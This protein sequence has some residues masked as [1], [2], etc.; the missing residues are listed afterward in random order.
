MNDT[1]LRE[2]LHDVASAGVGPDVD[3]RVARLASEAREGQGRSAGRG[4]RRGWT[5]GALGVAAVAVAVL[6]VV[7]LAAMTRSPVVVPASGPGSLPD[8]I[9]PTREHILTLEQ[10]PIGRV[11]MVYAGPLL[12]GATSWVA[13]GA[14]SDDYRALAPAS[15]HLGFNKSVDVAADG[16]T[17]AVGRGGRSL[18]VE[19]I[20]AG[21]GQSSFVSLPDDGAGG[22]VDSISWGSSDRRLAVTANIIDA[23]DPDRSSGRVSYYVVEADSGKVAALPRDAVLAGEIVGWTPDG[24]V[25]LMDGPGESGRLR[26]SAADEGGVTRVADIDSVPS[27]FGRP[28]ISPDGRLLAGLVDPTHSVLGDGSVWDLVVFDLVTG[29]QVY[30]SNLSSYAEDQTTVVGWRDATTP[31]LS[32]VRRSAE[33][34]ALLVAYDL[35]NRNEQVIVRAA[36]EEVFRYYMTSRVASDVLAAGQI[37]EAQPPEQPWYDPRTLGP[38]TGEWIVGHKFLVALIVVALVGTIVVVGRRRRVV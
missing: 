20:D 33:G 34:A 12:G 27:G 13:V 1:A 6:L 9:F 10:A 28:S 31:V 36:D 15:E 14:D 4:P 37:R 29:K 3:A 25:M 19:L 11:S 24:N 22:Y 18:Q 21:T 38:A 32:G 16:S 30:T 7:G 8:Q 35:D 2:A 5:F 26:L 23:S 17:V